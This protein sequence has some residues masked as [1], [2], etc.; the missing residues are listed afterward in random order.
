MGERKKNQCLSLKF[1]SAL[2]F[3][4]SRF[5]L[6]FFLRPHEHTG[7]KFCGSRG[8]QRRR[9]RSGDGE[10]ERE[11]DDGK[12]TK[13]NKKNVKVFLTIKNRKKRSRR[14]FCDEE[15]TNSIESPSRPW[16]SLKDG[17]RP[18]ADKAQSGSESV[19]R[20]EKTKRE[21]R[22]NQFLF[23]IAATLI[24]SHF[25]LDLFFDL[26]PF[27]KNTQDPLC[28]QPP[29]HGH[30]RGALRHLWQVRR[31]PPGAPRRR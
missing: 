15:K 17:V 28:P 24:S 6:P 20:L 23:F 10:R 14:D 18:P 2:S 31:R 5:A 29:L 4:L 22:E 3:I 21:I 7:R 8:W 9:Q 11:E 25:F 12:K 26:L 16:P 27:Q 19:S 1:S 13:N 30:P